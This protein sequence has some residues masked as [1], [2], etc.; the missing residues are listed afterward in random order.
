MPNGLRS[1]SMI[2]TLIL[3]AKNLVELLRP[4]LLTIDDLMRSIKW[5]FTFVRICS[6]AKKLI[7]C[8]L[9]V[10]TISRHEGDTSAR[11]MSQEA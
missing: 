9:F 2:S 4:A 11:M 8:L 6:W 1:L 3:H 7:L 10:G 5:V